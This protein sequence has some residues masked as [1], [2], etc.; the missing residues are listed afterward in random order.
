MAPASSGTGKKIDD[1]EMILISRQDAKAQKNIVT[2]AL[3]DALAGG[4]IFS[5]PGLNK[6]TFLSC[7]D[8]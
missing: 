2:L 6:E 5:F 8:F 3:A 1:I 7:R 4:G